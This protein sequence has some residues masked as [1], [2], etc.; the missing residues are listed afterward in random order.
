[1]THLGDHSKRHAILGRAGEAPSTTKVSYTVVSGALVSNISI[2]MCGCLL[3]NIPRFG[4]EVWTQA[5]D[6]VTGHDSR[7][8]SSLPGVRRI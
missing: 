1:M 4:S 7:K 8:V 6:T 5:Y 3:D 2:M